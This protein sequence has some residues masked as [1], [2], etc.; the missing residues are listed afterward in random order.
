L[1]KVYQ[2]R[3]SQLPEGRYVQLAVTDSGCGMDE[4]SQERIFE[5]FYTTNEV[6]EG[7]GL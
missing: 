3:L 5:P 1:L 2:P 4:A 7:T 6:G